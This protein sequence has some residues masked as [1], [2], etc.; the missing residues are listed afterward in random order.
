MD[1]KI[2]ADHRLGRQWFAID[3]DGYIGLFLVGD[4]G[5]VPEDAHWSYGYDDFF[6]RLGSSA[7]RGDVGK[8]AAQLG[9]YL[10]QIGPLDKHLA[11]RYHG[12]RSPRMPLHIDQVPPDIRRYIGL[13]QFDTLTFANTAVIQPVELTKCE[14]FDAGYLARDGKTVRMVPGREEDYDLFVRDVEKL[15]VNKGLTVEPPPQKKHKQRGKKKGQ[16]DA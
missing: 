14:T 10:Y 13:L 12:H 8:A 2:R 6:K 15:A 7:S 11:E 4:G 1:A 5:A 16:A 9:I 3:Q